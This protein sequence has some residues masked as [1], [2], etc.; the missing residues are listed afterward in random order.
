MRR[1][2][3]IRNSEI[4]GRD[5][6]TSARPAFGRNDMT[7]GRPRQPSWNFIPTEG[8][9]RNGLLLR[10]MNENQQKLAHDLFKSA[11]SQRGYMTATAI[12]EQC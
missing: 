2:F 8:F 7:A 10:D 12:M 1:E 3:G 9:P 4:E 6:S 11:L 5:P